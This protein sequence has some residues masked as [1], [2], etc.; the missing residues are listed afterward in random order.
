V[1]PV[2]TDDDSG[3]ETVH[4]AASSVGDR[5]RRVDVDDLGAR[6]HLDTGGGGDGVGQDTGEMAASNGK[7]VVEPGTEVRHLHMEDR[8]P[9]FVPDGDGRRDVG[10][11]AERIA[12]PKGVEHR[13]PVRMEEDAPTDDRWAL[14]AFEQRDPSAAAGEGQGG[15]A[16]ARSSPGDD[17]IEVHGDA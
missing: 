9:A 13:Q 6:D 5:A 4:V 14:E 3:R 16:A 7:H 2:G 12:E 17:D 1:D 8:P 10:T 15:D 11:A